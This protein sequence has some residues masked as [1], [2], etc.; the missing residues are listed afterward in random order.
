[1]SDLGRAP[2]GHG[3][4][5]GHGHGGRNY[6][7]GSGHGGHGYWPTST[8]VLIVEGERYLMQGIV[9]GVGNVTWWAPVVD[10]VGAYYQGSPKPTKI[11]ILEYHGG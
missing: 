5:H 1:M 6:S 3:G 7:H 9:P 10:M 4:G 2:H 8:E 11:S